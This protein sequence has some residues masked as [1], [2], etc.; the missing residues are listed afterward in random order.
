MRSMMLRTTLLITLL[1]LATA[2]ASPTAPTTTPTTPTAS[3]LIE[4]IEFR[5]ADRSGEPKV[6]WFVCNDNVCSRTD[7]SGVAILSLRISTDAFVI[8]RGPDGAYGDI[9]RPTGSRIEVVIR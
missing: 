2:C 4:R 8:F 9:Y 3:G 7:E 5:L 6:G 1:T